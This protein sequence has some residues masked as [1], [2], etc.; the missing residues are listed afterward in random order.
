VLGIGAGIKVSQ[1]G[2]PVDRPIAAM[3]DA[4]QIVRPLLRGEE[5]DYAGKIFSA[6]K[7]RLEY[8]LYRTGMVILMAAVGDQALRLAGELADGLMIS[9]MCPPAYTRRAVDI[10]LRAAEQA[11]RPRPAEV[12]QYA[13]CAVEDDGD[14]A[15][16][17]AKGLVGS[18]VTAFWRGGKAA[19]A[20]QSALRDYNG[21]DPDEFVR[22]MGRLAAGDA[23]EVVIDDRVAAQY[24]VAGAPSQCLEGVQAYRDAGV[25]ELGVWFAADRAIASIE[26]LGRVLSHD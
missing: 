11:G 9:N 13:P 12:V 24:A 18:M 16:R 14:E 25:T 8:P 21:V 23:A 10:L 5:I 26:R 20:S 7:V 3:R 17:L 19:P 6:E 15:R 1:M 2:L 22:M 4:I